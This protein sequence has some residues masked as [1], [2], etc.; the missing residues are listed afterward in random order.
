MKVSSRSRGIAALLAIAAATSSLGA[1][2]EKTKPPHLPAEKEVWLRADSPSFTVIGNVSAKKVVE[3]A[4][5]LERFRLTLLTLKP[6]ASPI[7]PVPTLFVAFTNDRSFDP[8]ET[9][10][11]SRETKWVG[12]YLTTP[13][14]TPSR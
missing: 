2:V 6:N 10:S 1:A 4:E 8:Y 14:G 11:D 9:S 12:S 7:S 3:I 5:A 13:C